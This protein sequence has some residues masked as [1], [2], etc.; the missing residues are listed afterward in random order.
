MSHKVFRPDKPSTEPSASISAA[1]AAIP[2][3]CYSLLLKAKGFADDLTV[4]SKDT[5]SHQRI[6]SSLV[7]RASD[8]CLEFQPPKCI[9]LNFNGHRMMCSPWQMGKLLIY[10][11]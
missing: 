5:K 6:L 9:S 2:K 3:T 8:V 7:L 11:T 10:V 1:T 4:I